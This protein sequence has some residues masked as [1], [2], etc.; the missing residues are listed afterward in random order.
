MKRALPAGAFRTVLITSAIG[1]AL[2]H[3]AALAADP[4][5]GRGLYEARCGGCHSESVHN[6]ASRKARSLDEVRA[7]V[8][9]FA[10]QLKTGWTPRDVDD[11]AVHLNEIFYRFPCDATLCPNAQPSGRTQ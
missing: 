4:G 5:R 8:A 10:A 3:P 11:V 1:A 7:R 9:H 6:D 2:A